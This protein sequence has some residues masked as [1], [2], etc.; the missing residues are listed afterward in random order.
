MN[1]PAFS[2]NKK[3]ERLLGKKRRNKLAEISN[4]SPTL[5]RSAFIGAN[6]VGEVDDWLKNQV[7]HIY[8][9]KNSLLIQ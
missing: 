2:K 5:R 3:N 6:E 8:T 7:I 4:L 9:H 1:F